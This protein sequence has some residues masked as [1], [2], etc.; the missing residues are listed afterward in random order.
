MWCC[1]AA[2]VRMCVCMF[3]QGGMFV[4]RGTALTL[5]SLLLQRWNVALVCLIGVFSRC[6]GTSFPS[7]EASLGCQSLGNVSEEL[8]AFRPQRQ[9]WE[10]TDKKL[11]FQCF[12]CVSPPPWWACTVTHCHFADMLPTVIWFNVFQYFSCRWGWRVT[13][14]S[15]RRL[16]LMWSAVHVDMCAAHQEWPWWRKL[17]AW[18]LKKEKCVLS[19]CANWLCRK[20]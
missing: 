17:S 13:C 15:R 5:S 4:W 8:D 12:C 3:E 14:T 10:Q 6:W 11:W 19:R 18:N 7:T 9:S 16:A 2:Q 20:G 1:I